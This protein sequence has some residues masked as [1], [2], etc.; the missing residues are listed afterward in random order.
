MEDVHFQPSQL[1]NFTSSSLQDKDSSLSKDKFIGASIRTK[2]EAKDADRNEEA[3]N[4]TP[5]SEGIYRVIDWPLSPPP[6]FV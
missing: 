6:K 4:D 2:D 3:I 1:W 5:Q